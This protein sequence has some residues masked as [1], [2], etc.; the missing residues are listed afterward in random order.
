MNAGGPTSS[1]APGHDILAGYLHAYA[2]A[3][4]LSDM[5]R[6]WGLGDD[7]LDAMWMRLTEALARDSQRLDRMVSEELSAEDRMHIA[8]TLTPLIFALPL[9]AYPTELRAIRAGSRLVLSMRHY[10]SAVPVHSPEKGSRHALALPKPALAGNGG[11]SKTAHE[12]AIGFL[13]ATLTPSFGIYLRRV[14][15]F[16]R[17]KKRREVTVSSGGRRRRV[18]V[19]LLANQRGL[20]IRFLERLPSAADEG[21]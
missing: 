7:A 11:K 8:S 12:E 4:Q 13:P 19:T 20:V 1:P 15:R 6:P 21:R 14:L 5:E 17:G 3:R 16:A 18:R 10:A 2:N 9:R